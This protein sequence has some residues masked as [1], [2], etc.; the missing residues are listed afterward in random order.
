MSR[1]AGVPFP[2]SR[3]TSRPPMPGQVHQTSQREDQPV[4]EVDY[5]LLQEETQPQHAGQNDS[6]HLFP[7][8]GMEEYFTIKQVLNSTPVTSNEAATSTSIPG[9]SSAASLLT[10]PTTVVPMQS[11]I[12]PAAP[13][14]EQPSPVVYNVTTPSWAG[15]GTTTVWTVAGRG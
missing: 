3:N 4:C 5:H 8:D 2:G 10:T 9:T 11:Q 1:Y 12:P 7:E 13:I 14:L 15:T 6:H